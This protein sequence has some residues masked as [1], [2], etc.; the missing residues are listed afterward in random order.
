MTITF[1]LYFCILFPFTDSFISQSP[2]KFKTN[3]FV[4]ENDALYEDISWDSGE[5]EWEFIRPQEV[6]FCYP[7][8]EPIFK[9]KRETIVINKSIENTFIADAILSSLLKTL[10]NE[11]VRM[12]S[13]LLETNE[14]IYDNLSG[15]NVDI[16]LFLLTVSLLL[17]FQFSQRKINTSS[18]AVLDNESKRK[19]F[20]KYKEIRESTQLLFL[21]FFFV[22]TKNVRN[23]E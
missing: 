20:Q 10:H 16:D 3:L 18:F 15:D 14:I 12:E 8:N 17:G 2:I 7:S 9:E 5:V 13:F 21:V 19:H 11:L 4:S 6:T 22:F 1:F 23:A